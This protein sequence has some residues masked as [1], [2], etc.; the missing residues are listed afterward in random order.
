MQ[1]LENIYKLYVRPHLDY[2]DIVF[3]TADLTQTEIFSF[4]NT[5]DKISM[6]SRQSNIKQLEL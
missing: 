5:N 2:G 6:K 1:T 4:K 3:D